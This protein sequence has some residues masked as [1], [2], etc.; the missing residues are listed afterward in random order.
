MTT[1]ADSVYADGFVVVARTWAKVRG[2]RRTGWTLHSAACWMASKPGCHPLPAPADPYPDTVACPHCRPGDPHQC[3]LSTTTTGQVTATCLACPLT[4][5]RPSR[6]LARS[7]L[8]H[9]HVRAESAVL[10]A[11]AVAAG[12]LTDVIAERNGPGWTLHRAACPVLARSLNKRPAPDPLPP[13]T[14]SCTNCHPPIPGPLPG[15]PGVHQRRRIKGPDGRTRILCSCGADT[16]ERRNDNSARA[17][18]RR[19]HNSQKR[20]IRDR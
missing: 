6:R 14:V 7:Q 1:M 18:L 19:I 8:R 13:D 12:T 9:A 11:E 5:T 2:V 4:V 10:Y 20:L 3:V 16:G 15:L 17:A